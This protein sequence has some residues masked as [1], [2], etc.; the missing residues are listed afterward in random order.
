MKLNEITIEVT[1]QCPNRCIYCS[2]L[3]DLEKTEAMDIKTVRRVVDD[4]KALGATIVSLSGG[5][6][7]LR[8]DIAEI[9]DYIYAQGLKIRLY[10]SGIYFSDGQYT[11][12]PATLLEA[13]KDKIEA[14]IFN[15]E[16]SDANLYATIMGTLH[17]CCRSQS[18]RLRGLS[19]PMS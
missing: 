9:V 12:I 2:S 1:Q 5:E 11:S 16:T 19:V 17:G 15:Y 6:P 8:N 4:A 10:S 13:V 7:F 14:L 18:T 3:S